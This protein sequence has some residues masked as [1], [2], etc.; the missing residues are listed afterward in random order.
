MNVIKLQYNFGSHPNS[1]S[2]QNP[3]I[4]FRNQKFDNDSDKSIFFRKQADTG[5]ADPAAD[6]L[7]VAAVVPEEHGQGLSV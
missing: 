6:D 4:L 2:T 5:A 1:F 3:K 7:A